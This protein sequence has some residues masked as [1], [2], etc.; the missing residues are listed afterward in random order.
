MVLNT[1]KFYDGT[2]LSIPIRP[3]STILCAN[4]PILASAGGLGPLLDLIESF[5]S[6]LL[7]GIVFIDA[8]GTLDLHIGGVFLTL[9]YALQNVPVCPEGGSK[10][11][12][13]FPTW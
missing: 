12:A 10:C 5:F 3:K 4:V 11:S 7:G 13:Y 2:A 8:K 9:P 6:A 1:D